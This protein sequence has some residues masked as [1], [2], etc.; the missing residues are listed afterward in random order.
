MW[1]VADPKRP[2]LASGPRGPLW[3]TFVPR[4]VGT[5]AMGLTF[6]QRT[7]V[8][9]A[10]SART[11]AD[12]PATRAALTTAQATKKLTK[13]C[14]RLV[15][16]TKAK[17]LKKLKKADRKARTRCLEQRRKLIADSKKQPAT[18][19]GGASP[20]APSTPDPSS[21]TSP[22]RP[23]PNTPPA[24][25]PTTPAPTTPA[26]PTGCTTP[27]VGDTLAVT[28]VDDGARF[29]VSSCGLKAGTIKFAFDTTDAAEE[30]NLVVTDGFNEVTDEGRTS[31]TPSGTMYANA[32][33]LLPGQPGRTT[34]ATLN[35]GDYWLICTVAGHVA[36]AMRFKVFPA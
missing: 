3:S 10:S 34:S 29:E 1:T 4:P 7:L 11:G 12:R 15:K 2:R 18:P 31:S 19:P 8:M 21:P 13:R 28:A 14:Q 17:D 25:T 30:H 9:Q 33:T 20:T 36:M 27:G 26:A 35:A 16:I 23:A 6:A 24:P 32:G 22:S 5:T